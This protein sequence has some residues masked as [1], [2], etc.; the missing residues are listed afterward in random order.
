M[1]RYPNKTIN[2][3]SFNNLIL[4][5]YVIGYKNIGEA[6]LVLFI[7]KKDNSVALS[8]VI[9]CYEI[10][11][12]NITDLY[13]KKHGAKYIDL[14]CWTH[15]HTDHSI[16]LDKLIKNYY[17]DSMLIFLPDFYHGK[18]AQD[19]LRDEA[20]KT[21]KIH[22]TI[23]DS[24][25]FKKNLMFISANA[26]LGKSYSI[27]LKSLENGSVKYL[28]LYFL[29]PVNSLLNSYATFGR[30]FNKP[31]N[32]SISF[33]M[34]LD[35]YNFF[36]GGDTEAPHA[37]R[38]PSE[39]IKQFRWIKIPHH[40]SFGAKHIAENLGDNLD[41][42]ASTVFYS[43][44]LPVKDIQDLYS[45]RSRLFM[46]QKEPDQKDSNYGVIEFIYLF[47]SNYIECQTNTYGNAY[48]Y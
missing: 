38:I 16:G 9:D 43:R 28:D 45:D 21:V 14:I 6:I 20:A 39:I 42:S 7:D 27:D 24:V 26:D 19:I 1:M 18:F 30:T 34:S 23:I 11:E 25:K 4:K 44:N 22:S 47:S 2:L 3:S 12:F 31:N 36:F 37:N 40:C 8:L 5:I 46:T 10:E 32:L 15:P 17:N 48:E 33:I 35:E 41:F 13:L 29:T